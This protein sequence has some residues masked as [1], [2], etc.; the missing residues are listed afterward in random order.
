VG[1][2]NGEDRMTTS[3][4]GPLETTSGIAPPRQKWSSGGGAGAPGNPSPS[5]SVTLSPTAL[6]SG[7]RPS[8][9]SIRPY[10]STSWPN[11]IERNQLEKI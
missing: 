2:A 11:S 6:H 5:Y 3:K 4:S 7:P 8:V 10:F 9:G 1:G